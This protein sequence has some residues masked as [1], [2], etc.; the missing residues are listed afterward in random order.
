MI[1]AGGVRTASHPKTRTRLSRAVWPWVISNWL[2][3]I[4]NSLAKMAS[5]ALF[6]LP[7][8][9]AVRSQILS[10]P[11]SIAAFSTFAPGTTRSDSSFRSDISAVIASGVNVGAAIFL[12]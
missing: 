9:G 11:F 5:T 2:T 6:A 10:A 3:D 4:P 8:S 7:S 12:R 1:H